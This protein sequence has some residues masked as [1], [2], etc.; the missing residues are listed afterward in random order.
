M[1]N[2]SCN[3]LTRFYRVGKRPSV[4]AHL[5]IYSQAVDVRRRCMSVLLIILGNNLDFSS[6]DVMVGFRKSSHKFIFMSI[7]SRGT[8]MNEIM[9]LKVYAG[10]LP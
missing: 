1:A 2:R 3:A 8:Q 4:K 5:A 10:I 9:S 7:F 6:C